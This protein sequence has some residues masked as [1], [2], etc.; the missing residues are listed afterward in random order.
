MEKE[1]K[2]CAKKRELEG[3]VKQ[4]RDDYLKKLGGG[5]ASGG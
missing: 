4:A 2:E 1:E 3:I 5:L